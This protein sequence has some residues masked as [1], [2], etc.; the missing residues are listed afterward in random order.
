MDFNS[1]WSQNMEDFER[2]AAEIEE[3]TRAR[4]AH[5]FAAFQGNAAQGSR[6]GG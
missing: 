6:V 5:D 3:A 4:H 2:Q 1:A